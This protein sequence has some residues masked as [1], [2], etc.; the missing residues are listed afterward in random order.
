MIKGD[1]NQ[2]CHKRLWNP[3][4]RL[5][6]HVGVH[7]CVFT[8]KCECMCVSVFA[9]VCCG[10]L[11]CICSCVHTR[12]CMCTCACVYTRVHVYTCVHVC[13]CAL[14]APVHVCAHVSVCAYVH[15]CVCPTGT[16]RGSHFEDR[17]RC[18]PP[19]GQPRCLAQLCTHLSFHTSTIW[20][21]FHQQSK[22]QTLPLRNE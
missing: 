9:H 21:C 6:T 3:L 12:A 15:T 13:S 17:F 8:S 14:C 16:C 18:P 20:G 11:M 22:L 5:C 4:G 19:A 10:S 7:I 2:Q 1:E